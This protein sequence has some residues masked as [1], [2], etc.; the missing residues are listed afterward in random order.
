MGAAA[1]WYHRPLGE[2]QRERAS[3]NGNA[4]GVV[5]T[6]VLTVPNLISFAR[7][8]LVP[9]F[10]GIYLAGRYVPALVI[11][12]V[13]GT[14]DWVDG[15]VARHTGQVSVLGKLLDPLADR[16]VIVAVL[17]AFAAKGTVPWWLAAVIAGR[18][19]IVMA[20]FAVLEKRGLPRLAV[21]R[22]GKL[23]TASIFTGLGLAAAGVV[24]SVSGVAELRADAHAMHIAGIVFLSA[25]AVLTWAAAALYAVE[26]R[27]ELRAKP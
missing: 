27:R 10:L 11:L 18:D 15:F 12:F 22:V 4:G 24:M 20:A 21:N 26:I 16:V 9:V 14:S 13:V 25:G 23:A 1:R 5:S 7:L 17:V 6:R 2:D 3:M 8:C 19:V